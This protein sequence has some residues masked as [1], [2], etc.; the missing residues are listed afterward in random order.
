MKLKDRIKTYNFWVSLSSAVFLM[1]KLLGE[2]IGFRVDESIFNDLITSLCGILVI[3]GIIVPPTSK[4]QT[5]TISNNV[6][7]IISSE[8]DCISETIHNTN[9][10]DDENL[11][12]NN[13]IISETNNEIFADVKKDLEYSQNSYDDV[14]E[15]E[16]LNTELE[17]T[18]TINKASKVEKTEDKD[19][20]LS[21][22]DNDA[23]QSDIE[24]TKINFDTIK[25]EVAHNLISHESLFK[26]D[27]NAY[28][29]LLQNEINLIRNR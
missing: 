3:L 23:I 29:E 1:I 14:I 27:I 20:S 25:A 22:Y 9:V 18:E 24:E 28:I 15:K 11:T 7:S 16:I 21:N 12:D 6:T 4:S 10:S 26:N 5:N 17:T 2:Q 13:Q 19:I 8:N